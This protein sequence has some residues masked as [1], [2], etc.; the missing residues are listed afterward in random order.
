M[1]QEIFIKLVKSHQVK[2]GLS[3]FLVVSRKWSDQL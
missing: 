3:A 2:I 1:T